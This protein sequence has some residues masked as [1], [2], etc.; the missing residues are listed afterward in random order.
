MV[1]ETLENVV[2]EDGSDEACEHS[3]GQRLGVL[4]WLP[5]LRRH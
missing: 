2:D 1:L 4:L 3:L 5:S